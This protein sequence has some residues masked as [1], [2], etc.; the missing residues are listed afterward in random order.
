[1]LRL[2]VGRRRPRFCLHRR[3]ILPCGYGRRSL[4][5]GIGTADRKAYVP[6]LARQ[7]TGALGERDEGAHRRQDMEKRQAGG[8][9]PLMFRVLA[10]VPVSLCAIAVQA[11][12]APYK[13]WLAPDAQTHLHLTPEQAKKLDDVF[14]SALSAR[15]AQRRALDALDRQL[16]AMLYIA[17][18]DDQHASTLTAP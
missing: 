17:M 7:R 1:M 12:S 2:G 13:W 6:C 18:A 15:R 3:L 4:F 14:E 8:H 10:F 5:V 11:K 9:R 16:D